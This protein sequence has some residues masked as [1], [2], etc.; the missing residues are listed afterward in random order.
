MPGNNEM[1]NEA[2]EEFQAYLETF[3][4]MHIDPRL[5]SRFGLSDVVQDTL[6]EAWRELKRLQ[7]LDAVGCKRRLCRMLVN[8]LLDRIEREQAGRRDV[9]REQS[10][11]VAV[12]ESSCRLRN[13]LAVEDTS[14]SERLMQQE[15]ELQVL[16]ALSHLD[17][18]Q[19][20]ALMLQKYH[21]YTLQEIAEHLGCTVGAVA[22]L[23]AR[24]LKELRKYLPDPE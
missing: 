13:W 2:L 8:N 7:A 14:P 3:K 12:Q 9:R 4:F 24:G 10:L 17:A 22:G 16:E 15:E 5:Q 1:V 6:A 18:R 21:A 19:R 20:D 11:D 23:H